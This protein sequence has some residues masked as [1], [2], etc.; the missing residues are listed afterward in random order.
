MQTKIF[1]ALIICGAFIL[2]CAPPPESPRV[3]LNLDFDW[4]FARGDFENASALD[5]D[6]SNWQQINVPHDWAVL[7]PVAE[8]NPSG[9]PGGFFTGGV[10][11]YRK[12]IEIPAEHQ[13]KKFYLTFDGIYRNSDVW[14]NGQKVGHRFYGYVTHYYDITPFLRFD[15]PNLLAVR[16]D[17]SQQPNDRWYAGCGIYRHVWL[18]IANP[19][20]IPIWGTYVTTPEVSTEQVQVQIEIKVR[21]DDQQITDCRLNV[22]ILDADG[23]LV[24]QADSEQ[25]VRAGEHT[26]FKHRLTVKSPKMWSPEQPYIYRA[27]SAVYVNNQ[28]VDQTETPFGIR[29]VVFSADSGLILNGKKVIMKG[30]CLH[31]DGGSVG[32]AVPDRM[33]ER[34]LEILKKIGVNAI[35]FAHNPHAPELL[36]MCNRLGFLVFDEAFDKWVIPPNNQ[37]LAPENQFLATWQQDLTDFID[38]DKNHPCVMLWSV[39]NEVNEQLS[40]PEEAERLLKMLVEHVHQQEPSRPVTYA[41]HPAHAEAGHEVPSRLIHEMD[42]VSYNYRTQNFKTWR[43]K[44]PDYVWIAS[45]T[46]AYRTDTPQNR[47]DIDYANN[48]WFF[49]NDFVAGQ[50]I[51]AGIDYLG[52]SRG[53]PDKGIRSGIIYTTGFIKPYGYFTQS[54]YDDN[55]MVHIVVLDDSLVHELETIETWQISWYGPPV[56]DHWTFPTKAGHTVQVLTY[57]NCEAV[58]LILNQESLG[59]KQLADFKDR[60]IRWQVPYEVGEIVAVGKNNNQEVSRHQLNTASSPT[61]LKLIPDRTELHADGRDVSHIEVRIEDKNGTLVPQ[62]RHLVEFALQGTGKIIGLDNGDMSDHT[63]PTSS[64]ITTRNGRCLVIVQAARQ[65]GQ[66]ELSATSPG[67][68]SAQL[69]L[70]VK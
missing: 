50:F 30:V 2:A 63:L 61:H 65:T 25:P 20:H 37:Q 1:I 44:W 19:L 47:A 14:L 8:N 46:K 64:S 10:G 53:W 67:L 23:A 51:W 57:T 62:A 28:L 5:F 12:S 43:E 4:K 15:A 11:W 40:D 70:I 9:N 3:Q 38:R 69:S 55:P 24:A 21:N 60:V 27:V 34:R 36:E 45:E 68:T 49:L 29:S 42:L 52:E 41:L 48:S 32:A 35:R 26:T 17:A 22:Q 58:E 39:G 13:S 59:E 7:E 54:I 6:D 56:A 16:V 18:T 31:H 66:I 33:W